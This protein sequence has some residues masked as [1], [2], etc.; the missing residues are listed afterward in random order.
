MPRK[1]SG[2]KM[3]NAERMR[4]RREAHPEQHRA[5]AREWYH[6]NLETSRKYRTEWYARN[7]ERLIEKFRTSWHANNLRR[8]KA[9][10]K[11]SAAALK[12][13]LEL[14]RHRCA[15]CRCS[16]RGGY[17][18][19]HIN[20]IARGGTHD[21]RNIQI[22]CPACNMSKGAKDPA[23]FMRSRGLHL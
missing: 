3:T 2:P 1:A 7:K 22:L 17:H 15:I 8:R 20:P 16:V 23:S 10:G 5:A 18:I 11:L 13:I 19:D 21:R 14:Q 6:N 9:A 12:E 4:R